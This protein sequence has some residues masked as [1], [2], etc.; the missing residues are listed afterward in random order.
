MRSIISCLILIGFCVALAQQAVERQSEFLPKDEDKVFYALGLT[1]ARAARNFDLSS[2]ELELVKQGFTDGV[3]GR[4]RGI[5][6]DDFTAKISLMAQTRM[7]VLRSKELAV[8]RIYREKAATIS[9]ARTTSSGLVVINSKNGSL[10][11]IFSTD[12]VWLHVIGSSIDGQVF[13]DSVSKGQ[14][15]DSLVA[16]LL[17]CWREAI[18]FMTVGEKARVICPPDLTYGEIGGPHGTKPGATL[19]FDI[20]VLRATK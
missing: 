2:T 6:A 19:V 16:N 7:Q 18:L 13:A 20:T 10:D 4:G 12:R 5:V 15:I 3:L 8:G 17:P 1:M 9:N 14:P 11:R